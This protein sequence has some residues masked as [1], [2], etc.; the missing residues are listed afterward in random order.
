MA[1]PPKRHILCV[2]DSSDSCDLL[3]FVLNQDGYEVQTAQTIADG[4]HL[5]KSNQFDLYILDV[6]FPNGTGFD[7]C[8]QI[9][10]FD[11]STPVVFCS[12]DVR[13]ATQHQAIEAGAQAFLMKP[14][15]LSQFAETIARF[16]QP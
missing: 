10:A 5:A 16:L 2:D 11:P 3:R 4:L 6:T 13:E 14:L 12:A 9:R 1:S 7:L 8:R 15:D